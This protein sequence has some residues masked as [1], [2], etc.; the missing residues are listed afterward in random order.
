MAAVGVSESVRGDLPPGPTGTTGGSAP[1]GATVTA[2]ANG[3]RGI[4]ID[5]HVTAVPTSPTD[6]EAARATSSAMAALS[7][8]GPI[9]S[10]LPTG[11]TGTTGSAVPTNASGA[12]GDS[13]G[14]GVAVNDRAA[15]GPPSP[16]DTAAAVTTSA[17]TARCD[18]SRSVHNDLSTGPTGT[19]GGPGPTRATVTAGAG[20]RRRTGVDS[21]A[22]AVP[23]S[24]ADPAAV[25]GAAGAAMPACDVSGSIG[26]DRPTGPTGTTRGAVPALTTDAAG[27]G[28]R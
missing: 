19:T 24:P 2:G 20:S 23:T 9:R 14:R 16:T 4:A 15:A 17:A 13:D 7:F 3:R 28:D 21:H 26:G 6:A 27:N 5:S 12:A 25:S 22:T 18:G 8:S 11:P 10:D 1:T